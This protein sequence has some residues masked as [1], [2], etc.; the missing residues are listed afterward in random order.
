MPGQ[1]ESIRGDAGQVLASAGAK[2]GI[3]S[4]W[5][6][7]AGRIKPDGTPELSFRAQFSWKND[8]LMNMLSRGTLKGR[9]QVTFR[10]KKGLETIDIVA[11]DQW[12]MDGGILYLDNVTYF[13]AAKVRPHIVR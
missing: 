11:W 8:V 9:V 12:R 6:L 13:D 3:I 2:V 7:E 5:K 4:R 10:S 1:F